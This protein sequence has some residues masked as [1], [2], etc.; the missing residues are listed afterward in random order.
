MVLKDV[1]Y[2]CILV[3]GLSAN[4]DIK[5]ARVY[6][7]RSRSKPNKKKKEDEPGAPGKPSV[8]AAP[9]LGFIDYSAMYS[10][11]TEV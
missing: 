1:G 7:R 4:S 8:F 9:S 3:Y 5:G 2:F 10:S 11:K 6:R